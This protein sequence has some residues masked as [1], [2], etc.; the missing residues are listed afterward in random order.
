LPCSGNPQAAGAFVP[1]KQY[2]K[3]ETAIL[4]PVDNSSIA[5]CSAA[6][7]STRYLAPMRVTI[8]EATKAFGVAGKHVSEV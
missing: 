5:A 8:V 1:S 4:A 6:S 7:A 3:L 2:A